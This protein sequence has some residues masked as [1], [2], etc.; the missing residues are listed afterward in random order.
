MAGSVLPAELLHRYFDVRGKD[1]I[2]ICGGDVHG[3]P[4]ELEALELGEDPQDIKDEKTRKVKEAYESLNVDF[5]IFSD[6]HSEYNR[7]Q[8]HEMFEE[9]YCNGLID[10]KTQTM[11]Y[12]RDDERFLPD[13]YIEG[14]CPHC[15]GLARG[16]QCDDCGKLVE[17]TE[18]EN[19]ECQICGG[20]S[21]E[22]RETDHLFLD[23][24]EFK[25]EL[26]EWLKEEKPIPEN[27]AN[28]VRHD[29]EEA[30]ERSITRDQNW[31]FKVPTERINERIDEE[32]LDLKKLDPEKYDE[33]VLYVWFD[34]PIG[35]I[36]FTRE[37]FEDNNGWKKHWDIEADIYYSIGKDNTIFH[38]VIWP[39]MLLGSRNEEIEYGLPKYEFIQ[40]YL[41][42]EEGAF[43]KSRDR[44]IFIDEA[45]EHYPADYW[46]FYLSKMLPTDHD[47][48]FSW[49][50]FE[51]E[52]N[53]VLNDTVGNFVNRTLSLAEKWFDNEVPKADLEESDREVIEE[54]K[55][56]LEDYIEAFEDHEPQEALGHSLQIARIGDRYLSEE[57]PWNNED[58]REET[59]YVALQLIQK[60]AVTLY[61]FIPES[62]E[63]IGSMLNT[64]VETS[65]NR[66]LLSKDVLGAVEAGQELGKREILFEKIDVSDQV[67]KLE[68]EKEEEKDTM[69]EKFNEDTVLFDQ[70]SEMDLRVGKV[71]SVEEHPNADKLYRVKVDVGEAVLQ[72][73]AGLKNFYK[74]EELEGRKVVVLANLEPA[75]LRGE[76]SECMML[77]AESDDGETVS[78]LTTD[79]ETELGDKIK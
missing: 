72:T 15:G 24:T 37:Y 74:S 44:G 53:N 20:N 38:T 3:T 16:D 43:S 52:I 8:T 40:Q 36:G 70:F 34:A 32:N 7:K 57:E 42:W 46:R 9:L 77:A 1:S 26:K 73:C 68:E 56:E 35:Y 71:E 79:Q 76:K 17:P 49:E 78:L 12:C 22:F 25:D 11:P 4:L 48:N 66:D 18:I 10:E 45:V 64:S 75:E 14:E 55:K 61:P 63:K 21:I 62:S 28:Q 50:D 51:S 41:M 65:E 6:T 67:Q 19:A 33:K 5:T 54:V 58:R 23:L 60:L 2:F 59:I 31:G 13:R 27:M 47:T 30:E 69:K 29:I 39:T